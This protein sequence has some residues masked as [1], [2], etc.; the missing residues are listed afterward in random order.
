MFR[1]PC[2]SRLGV[3]VAGPLSRSRLE[4]RGPASES[5]L[6]VRNGPAPGP[7]GSARRP[8]VRVC[9]RGRGVHRNRIPGRRRRVRPGTGSQGWQ[10]HGGSPTR[11]PR[12]ATQGEISDADPRP[13]AT[14][15]ARPGPDI[16][17]NSRPGPDIVRNG[18]YCNI[19]E[20]IH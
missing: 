18:I 13:R 9:G 12:P 3:A 8:V 10:G 6:P 16:L 2:R 1:K 4:Q 20:Y 17:S 15:A 19:S 5:G 14:R 7:G 11:D